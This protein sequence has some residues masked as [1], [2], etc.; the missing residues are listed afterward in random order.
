MKSN[1]ST[2]GGYL[3][4]ENYGAY[5]DWSNS[6]VSALADNGVPLYAASVQNEPNINVDYESTS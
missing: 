4:P 2:V 6:F 3:L 5:V 1:N